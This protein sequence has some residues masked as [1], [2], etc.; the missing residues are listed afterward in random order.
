VI[1][2]NRGGRRSGADTGERRKLVAGEARDDI[3]RAEPCCNGP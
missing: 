3:R 1:I 2:E